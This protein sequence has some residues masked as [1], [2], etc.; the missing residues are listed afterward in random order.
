[1]PSANLLILFSYSAFSFALDFD[2]GFEQKYLPTNSKWNGIDLLGYYLAVTS[3]ILA[4][5]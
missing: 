3:V 1:M 5:V 4:I 2:L